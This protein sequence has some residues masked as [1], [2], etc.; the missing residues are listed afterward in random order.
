MKNI[1]NIIA[2][3]TIFGVVVIA[4]SAF[5]LSFDA[6]RQMA[7]SHGVNEALSWMFPISL[8]LA[9]LVYSLA[10]ILR[11]WQGLCAKME[12]TFV[13]ASTVISVAL[14]TCSGSTNEV[15]NMVLGFIIHALPPLFMAAA[16]EAATRLIS[17][18]VEIRSMRS[19]KGAVTRRRRQKELA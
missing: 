6:L 9:I 1:K 4:V 17:A 8:D 12:I 11:R 3:S 18:P 16:V 13:V 14:N 7:I 15:L 5:A 2:K 10:S 19:K